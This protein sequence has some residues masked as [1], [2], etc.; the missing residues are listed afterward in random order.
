MCNHGQYTYTKRVLIWST[1][2]KSEV[3]KYFVKQTIQLHQEQRCDSY[4]YLFYHIS[5]TR[6]YRKVIEMRLPHRSSTYT[7][8]PAAREETLQTPEHFV[9]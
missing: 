9:K 1:V 3:E 2:E 4:M 6:K 8:A 5:M 7:T